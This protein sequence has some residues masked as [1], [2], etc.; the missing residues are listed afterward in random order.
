[1]KPSSLESED[2]KM[3]ETGSDRDGQGEESEWMAVPV[4]DGWSDWVLVK[5]G[6]PI[7]ASGVREIDRL[8][9]SFRSLTNSKTKGL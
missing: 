9:A 7:V 6:G 8:H 2:G 5:R 3:A 4:F 1:M